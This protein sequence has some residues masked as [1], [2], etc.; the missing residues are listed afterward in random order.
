M[1]TGSRWSYLPFSVAQSA[2]RLNVAPPL[3]L[4]TSR[5]SYF[6]IIPLHFAIENEPFRLVFNR[7]H[8][9]FSITF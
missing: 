1:W 6:F 9:M 8:I 7:F 4:E 2:I 5:F 3:D